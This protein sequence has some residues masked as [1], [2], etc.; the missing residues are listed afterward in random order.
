MPRINLALQGG[1]S[2]GAFTWGVLDRLLE[3]DLDIVGVSGTSAGACNAVLLA[4]GWVEAGPEQARQQLE[5]FWKLVSRAGGSSPLRRSLYSQFMGEY[6]LDTSPVHFWLEIISRLFSPYQ[7]NPGGDHPLRSLLE[8][9]VDFDRVRASDHVKVFVNTTNVLTGTLRIFRE[10]EMTV[11][12][13]LAS[14]CLPSLFHAIE[15]DGVPYW[16]GGYIANP[17]LFPM[18]EATGVQD[19]LIVQINPLRIRE[20]PIDARD[21]INR[22]G[23]ITFNSSL[24]KEVRMIEQKNA[25]IRAGELDPDRFP[26]VRLHMIHGGPELQRFDNSSKLLTEMEFLLELKQIGR[27][28]AEDWIVRHGSAVGQTSSLDAG[29][30]IRGELE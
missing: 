5:G 25:L 6:T 12:M 4:E 13:V 8:E 2:H 19:I 16:D 17:A 23:E 27:Q 15:I 18:L 14:T 9:F 10:H 7:L 28:A 11:D 20:A 26:E 21:I 30:L 1:G 3:E 24:I 22:L 29:A